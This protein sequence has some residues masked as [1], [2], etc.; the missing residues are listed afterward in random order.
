MP[1]YLGR[2]LVLAIATGAYIGYLPVAPGTAG[3]IVGVLVGALLALL[4]TCVQVGLL[5]GLFLLGVLSSTCA[6][7]WLAAEDP[8]VVVI[9]EIVGMSC[10]LFALPFEAGFVIAAFVLFRVLDILKPPPIR[11]LERWPGGWGIMCD[12]LLAG[13]LTNIVLQG[14]RMLWTQNSPLK[15]MFAGPS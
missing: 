9:D 5:L 4:P 6:S 15:S 7:R 2:Q 13:S 10:G 3:S 14:L 8:P 1:A 12:D 11:A